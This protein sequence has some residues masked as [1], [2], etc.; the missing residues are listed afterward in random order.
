MVWVDP[1]TMTIVRVD[2][3][4][5]SYTSTQLVE[6]SSDVLLWRKQVPRS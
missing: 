6:D 2:T 5:Q 3:R 4:H 1:A